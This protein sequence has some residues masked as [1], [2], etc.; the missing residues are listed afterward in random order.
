MR[1]AHGESSA[2]LWL[3]PSGW[4]YPDWH[5]PVYPDPPPR[6]FSPLR[7][8]AR[9]FN[10]IEVNSSFYRI[11]T[12]GVTQRW[13]TEVPQEFRF[14][15]KL[16]RSF[17]HERSEFPPRRDFEAFRDGLRPVGEAGRLGPILMQFPWSFRY[18]PPSVDW[19]RRLADGLAGQALFTEVRHASW[20]SPDAL[21]ALA[22]VGGVCAI[23]QPRL[24][25]CIGP[26]PFSY[27]RRG[28]VRLHGRNAAN[29]FADDV[30]PFERYN[31]LYSHPELREWVERLRAM[32]AECDDVWVFANNHY[33]G[34][35]VANAL[36]LRAMLTGGPVTVPAELAAAY[37][38]LTAFSTSP[39]QPGLF[40]GLAHPPGPR[41]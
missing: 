9:H 36:E 18:S 8:M 10:A 14:A 6:G 35:G 16:T 5:G 28:Y 38:R 41:P 3:G 40:D 26:L 19:V 13:V 31:Y 24:H 21:E 7:F 27:G 33:R 2:R 34:Q 15:F 39:R 12:A 11:P 1:G 25:D 22:G 23:D 29:W 37:P 17:T 32:A 4:S 30:P 20:L